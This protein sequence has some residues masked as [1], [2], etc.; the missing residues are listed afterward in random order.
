MSEI[1][2]LGYMGTALTA[3]EDSQARDVDDQHGQGET[4]KLVSG[5][6]FDCLGD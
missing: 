6:V 5:N 3:L 4:Q 2:Y 1:M